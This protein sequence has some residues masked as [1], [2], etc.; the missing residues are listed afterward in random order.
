MVF[1]HVEFDCRDKEVHELSVLAENQEGLANHVDHLV[2]QL[3]GVEV[4]RDGE[5]F[6]YLW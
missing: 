2:K 4:E 5:Q 3:P 1:V 6:D